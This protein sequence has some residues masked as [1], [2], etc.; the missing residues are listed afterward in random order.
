MT[1]PTRTYFHGD[2]VKAEGL[3]GFGKKVLAKLEESLLFNNLP[4]GT[5]GI[6]FQDGSKI[7]AKVTF[8]ETIIN[9][10]VPTEGIAEQVP[11][12]LCGKYFTEGVI[13]GVTPVDGYVTPAQ[14][15]T[16][17]ICQDGN[18]QITVTNCVS[19]DFSV[20]LV[21]E[22]VWCCL[23]IREMIPA[24]PHSAKDPIYVQDQ[25]GFSQPWGGL[26]TVMAYTYVYDELYTRSLL[27]D[28]Y[29]GYNIE[30]GGTWY[31]LSNTYQNEALSLN[32]R[33]PSGLPLNTSEEDWFFTS[34]SMC[35]LS[36]DISNLAWLFLNYN[37]THYEE[38]VKDAK[39]LYGE[40]AMTYALDGYAPTVSEDPKYLFNLHIMKMVVMSDEEELV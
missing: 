30:L 1:V 25:L 37:D 40:Y 33:L 11:K 18:T 21:G 22:R 38:F 14:L 32:A 19:Q 4:T 12:C 6:T 24:I 20:M 28:R 23:S 2:K 7:T 9:I 15:Y 29:I 35:S 39:T 8:T 3:Q 10:F 36:P 31:L 27:S 5:T 13:I 26:G 17:D 16:V 34:P